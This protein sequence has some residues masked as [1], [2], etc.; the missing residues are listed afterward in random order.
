MKGNIDTGALNSALFSLLD[1]FYNEQ[2]DFLAFGFFTVKIWQ[3]MPRAFF[4]VQV[5]RTGTNTDFLFI[6]FNF[7][8][9]RKSK[10]KVA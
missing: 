10:L 6:H 8:R 1:F 7:P 5:S 3:G 9:K 2:A 4:S